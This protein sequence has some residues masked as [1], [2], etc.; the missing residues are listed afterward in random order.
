MMS[1]VLSVLGLTLSVLG[2]VIREMGAD[3]VARE[4]S[5]LPKWDLLAAHP[6]LALALGVV[7]F[8]AGMTIGS[9]RTAK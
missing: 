3:K 9:E 8:A 4:L 6:T 1:Y 5:W 7:L 2:G